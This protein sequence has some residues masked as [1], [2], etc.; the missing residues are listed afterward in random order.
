VS[1]ACRRAGFSLIEVILATAI[2]MG[3]LTVLAQLARL[4][5]RNARAARLEMTAQLLCESKLA[6]IVCGVEP[7]EEKQPH[8]L[9]SVV[10]TPLEQPGLIGV[11]VT[12]RDDVP[13]GRQ[14][15]EVKLVRWVYKPASTT[16]AW[17]KDRL[18]PD[19]GSAPAPVHG[20]L[21]GWE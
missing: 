1:T 5:Y 18:R 16:N 20:S 9:Y 3:S 2:L 19:D 7:A 4:G 11:Q 17:S 15:T 8:W 6:E 21:P 10:V 13:E 14:A 12:V